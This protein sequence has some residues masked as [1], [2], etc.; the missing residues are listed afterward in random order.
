MGKKSLL[1]ELW[2]V[3]GML[4]GAAVSLV[5]IVIELVIL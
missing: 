4:T 2:A 5:W 3:I 1:P